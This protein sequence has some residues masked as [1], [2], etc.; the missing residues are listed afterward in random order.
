MLNFNVECIWAITYVKGKRKGIKHHL[1][2][3]NVWVLYACFLNY[4]N[5]W[6]VYASL[7]ILMY[8]YYTLP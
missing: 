1:N 7:T 6:V 2:Y 3:L 8:G 4:L 5:A